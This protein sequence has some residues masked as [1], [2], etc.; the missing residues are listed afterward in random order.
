MTRKTK[1]RIL[2]AVI[3]G[4]SM[5]PEYIDVVNVF[6][7]NIC[8]PMT[9]LKESNLNKRKRNERITYHN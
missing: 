1:K 9:Y 8:I 2:V 4:F 6:L 5:F 3:V 7:P